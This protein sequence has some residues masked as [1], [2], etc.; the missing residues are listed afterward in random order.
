MVEALNVNEDI[1]I[2]DLKPGELAVFTSSRIP[3]YVGKV[4]Q[5]VGNILFI[6]GENN[7]FQDYFRDPTIGTRVVV[8][9][10]GS[11]LVVK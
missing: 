11:G 6:V 3:W 8:L 4:C 10:K 1:W 9:K 7:C 2:G 5:R